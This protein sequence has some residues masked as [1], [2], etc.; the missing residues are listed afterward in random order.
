MHVVG[1]EDIRLHLI[2]LVNKYRAE[3]GTTPGQRT[4]LHL[5]ES[6]GAQ[7]KAHSNQGHRQ[8]ML[9][10]RHKAGLDIAHR[11]EHGNMRKVFMAG[12]FR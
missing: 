6:M 4:P 3:H 1:R 7:V 8:A 12:R 5:N 9:N 2:Y 10:A 11:Y